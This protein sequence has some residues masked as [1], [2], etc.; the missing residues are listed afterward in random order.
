MMKPAEMLAKHREVWDMPTLMEQEPE[1]LQHLDSK[2]EVH[3]GIASEVIVVHR[4]PHKVEGFPTN[5]VREV[6]A[7][8]LEREVAAEGVTA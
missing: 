5:D 1:V 7:I 8:L 4:N 3:F 2:Y 6:V